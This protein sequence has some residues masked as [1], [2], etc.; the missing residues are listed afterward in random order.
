[1]SYT[2]YSGEGLIGGGL[3][4]GGLIGGGLIGG[5]LIGGGEALYH[6]KKHKRP[7]RHIVK[8]HGDVGRIYE[9]SKKYKARPHVYNQGADTLTPKERSKMFRKHAEPKRPESHLQQEYRKFFAHARENKI[10]P[11]S[12]EFKNAWRRRKAELGF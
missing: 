9:D 7:Y 2:S 3:I 6:T 8:S 4:G 12:E 11:K 1:M 10:N 5:G